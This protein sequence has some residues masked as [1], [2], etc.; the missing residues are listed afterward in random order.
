MYC[1][2]RLFT[3]I[4]RKWYHQV[5]C[6]QKCIP[7]NIFESDCKWSKLCSNCTKERNCSSLDGTFRRNPPEVVSFWL[8]SN[9]NGPA[10]EPRRL[11]RKMKRL[12]HRRLWKGKPCECGLASVYPCYGVAQFCGLVSGEWTMNERAFRSTSRAR[13]TESLRRLAGRCNINL[14]TLHRS[15]SFCRIID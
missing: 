1:Q 2:N 7:W 11:Q 3:R 9:D 5:L 10:P 8:A 12:S 6:A 14:E 4:E 15:I 13:L